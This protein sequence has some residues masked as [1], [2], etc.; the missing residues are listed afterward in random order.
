MKYHLLIILDNIQDYAGGSRQVIPWQG[1]PRKYTD[2]GSVAI[3]AQEGGPWA[4]ARLP[5]RAARFRFWTCL[6]GV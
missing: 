5:V 3:G 1:Q 4:R 2:D 6:P